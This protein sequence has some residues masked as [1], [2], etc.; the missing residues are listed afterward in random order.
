MKYSARNV[1]L[2][3]VVCVCL[4]LFGSR[5]I[6]SFAASAGGSLIQL[7][8]NRVSTEEEVENAMKMDAYQVQKDI[9]DM[10]EPEHSY[11]YKD[12]LTEPIQINVRPVRV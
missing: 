4:I 5:Y 1:F 3:I 8:A 11:K 12:I 10:T 9:V 7:T 6:E 2:L